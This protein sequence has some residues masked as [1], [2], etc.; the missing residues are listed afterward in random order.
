MN[1]DHDR[2]REDLAAYA[3]GALTEIETTS[4]VRHLQACDSCCRDLERF[5]TVIE[6]LSATV[7]PQRAREDLKQ[8]VLQ[9]IRES[10]TSEMHRPL[11][12]RLLVRFAP[13]RPPLALAGALAALV[14]VA[15]G[16]G[17]GTAIS[18]EERQELSA[19]IDRTRAPGASATL[20]RKGDLGVL[21]V[22]NLAPLA[23]GVYVVWIDRGSGPAYASSFNVGSARTAEA[24]V[25]GLDAVKRVMVTPEGTAEVPQPT[26][27]PILT[28]EVQ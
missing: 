3:L 26:T 19:S 14:L 27:R 22:S 24:G 12:R 8:E 21:R 17:L 7:I 25:T 18:E 28:V 5:R 13:R 23:D 20:E 11:R 16:Y 2:Y 1:D 15:G 6:T 9:R 10:E 4:L